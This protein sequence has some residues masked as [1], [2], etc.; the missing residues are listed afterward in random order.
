[1]KKNFAFSSIRQQA[2]DKRIC[3][4][5]RRASGTPAGIKGSFAAVY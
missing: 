5:R 3:G 4:H 1:L 2:A